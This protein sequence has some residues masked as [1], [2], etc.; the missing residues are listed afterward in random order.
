MKK[1]FLIFV[2]ASLRFISFA[3]VNVLDASTIP[4]SLKENTHSVK[5]EEKIDF[6]VKDFW[7]GL[8]HCEVDLGCMGDIGHRKRVVILIFLEVIVIV[9]GEGL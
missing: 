9:M 3:Q 4:A 7:D 6:E 8:Q 1:L 5:R 2:A